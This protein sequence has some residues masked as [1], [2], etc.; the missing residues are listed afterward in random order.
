MGSQSYW[1]YLYIIAII[2]IINILA[3]LPNIFL[4]MRYLFRPSAEKFIECQ[5]VLNQLN[6]FSGK[7]GFRIV[8]QR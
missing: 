1:R 2:V 7:E 8:L 4:L 3:V 5:G 6:E